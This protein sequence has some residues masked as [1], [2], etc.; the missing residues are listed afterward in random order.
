LLFVNPNQTDALILNRAGAATNKKSGNHNL[1]EQL[2][3]SPE[4]GL[5]KPVLDKPGQRLRVET[6]PHFS[7][8]AGHGQR[9]RLAPFGITKEAMFCG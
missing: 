4:C 7:C 6:H 1:E 8:V 5:S 3:L 9:R 2:K